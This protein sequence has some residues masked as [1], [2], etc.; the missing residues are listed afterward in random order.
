ME[1]ADLSTDLFGLS[2]SFPRPGWAVLD[3]ARDRRFTGELVCDSSPVVRVYLDRGR[4]YLAERATDSGL[5]ARLVDA[6]VVSAVQLEH[7]TMRVGEHDHLGRLFERVPSIDRHSVM[8]I[9]ELMS[10]ECVGWLAAQRVHGVTARPYHHHPSGVQRWERPSRWSDLTPGDPLPAPRPGDEPVEIG[11]PEPLF[12]PIDEFDDNLIQWD[13][14][15][16]LDERP[17]SDSRA[18]HGDPTATQRPSSG[19][20]VGQPPLLVT[21]SDLARPTVRSE[22]PPLPAHPSPLPAEQVP[23]A[24]TTETDPVPSATAPGTPQPATDPADLAGPA[25]WVDRLEHDGLP[26]PGDDPLTVAFRFPPTRTEP[27]DRFELI[28][29]TGEIDEDFDAGQPTDLLGTHPDLDFAGQTARI[30]RGGLDRV[31]EPEL[32]DRLRDRTPTPANESEADEITDEVVL[33]VRRA[34]AQIETGSLDSRRRLADVTD[35]DGSAHGA[36]LMMPGRL[37]VRDP[38]DDP[39]VEMPQRHH[40]PVTP[41]SIFGDEPSEVVVRHAQPTQAEEPAAGGRVGALRRL[42]SGLRRV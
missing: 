10:D 11:P 28:W 35:A 33:S 19:P 36:D 27:V 31:D 22:S 13:E 30:M 25:D 21:P 4:I 7:G 15:S 23:S 34:V 38:H 32:P 3:T 40:V 1:H 18:R 14:P 29:P 42:I 24:P 39:R 26:E 17:P 5:G 8:V 41:R 2:E 16:W 20:T 37:A 9:T 12:S 6:G